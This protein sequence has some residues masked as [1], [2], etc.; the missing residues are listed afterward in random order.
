MRLY[1]Y[2]DLSAPGTE[3]F[4]R[5]SEIL[6]GNT[7]WC[8]APSTLN[9]PTE[10]VWECDYEPSDRTTRI[11]ENVLIN[12]GRTAESARELAKTAVQSNLVEAIAR[13]I[14]EGMIEKC[15]REVGLACFATS[16]DNN[17]MWER[18][19]GQGN[20]VCVEIEVP[21][22]LLHLHLHPVEYPISKRL[23]LDQLLASHLDRSLAKTVYTVALLSKPACWAPES[24]VRFV[25]SRQNVAVQIFGSH[26]SRII[27]GL[28]LLGEMSTMI[29]AFSSSLPYEL[30][31]F[32][33]G[34]SSQ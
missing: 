25:S 12:R 14:F 16:G 34:V 24:E 2:R 13:P 10:F 23:H 21:D 33:R 11:L 19:G 27:L 8:A 28:A 30:C 20:G 32:E 1:K 17:V 15:R 22:E 4:E 29:K 31:M 3:S 9:D 26:I 7:F 6:R 5:L 18:Y